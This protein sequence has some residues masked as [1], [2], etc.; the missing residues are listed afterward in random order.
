MRKPSLA[1]LIRDTTQSGLEIHSIEATPDGYLLTTAPQG[2][3]IAR[4]E[5]DMARENR[6]RAREARRPAN[7]Y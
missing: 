7:G 1:R 2:T 5:L 3:P 6:R 4:S